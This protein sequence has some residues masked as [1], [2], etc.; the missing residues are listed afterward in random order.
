[1]L[2]F[3]GVGAHIPGTIQ[4]HMKYVMDGIEK[5]LVSS[6]SS[7]QKMLRVSAD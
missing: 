4:E 3:S 7:L 6:G 5:T 1:M 2:F